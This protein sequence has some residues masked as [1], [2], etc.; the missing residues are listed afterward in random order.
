MIFAGN[1]FIGKLCP[2]V[3]VII[4]GAEAKMRKKLNRSTFCSKKLA[5]TFCYVK[6]NARVKQEYRNTDFLPH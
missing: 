1:L 5:L 6:L 3:D 2:T 4:F